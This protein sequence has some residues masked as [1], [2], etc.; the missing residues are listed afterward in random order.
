M[1]E[2]WSYGRLVV[3]LL[4]VCLSTAQDLQSKNLVQC[5]AATA[6]TNLTSLCTSC[7]SMLT[8]SVPLSG[9]VTK[10]DTH[11]YRLVL[12]DGQKPFIVTLVTSY[13]NADLKVWNQ[14]DLSQQP[15]YTSVAQLDPVQTIEVGSD[16]GI[17]VY[18]IGVYNAG[19]FA[20]TYS[21]SFT[22]TPRKLSLGVAFPHSVNEGCA[23]YYEF[24]VDKQKG[25]SPYNLTAR[26]DQLQIATEH[27]G[28]SD[29]WPTA[30]N[31]EFRLYTHF[32][33]LKRPETDPSLQPNL[34]YGLVGTARPGKALGYTVNGQRRLSGYPTKNEFTL[35][36]TDSE[37]KTGKYYLSVQLKAVSLV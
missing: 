16:L 26:P 24:Q 2:P 30:S 20:S 21:V 22:T 10:G 19:L 32:G 35:L 7:Y 12:C 15:D 1:P 4:C 23:Q 3:A 9:V 8:D 25:Q 6:C 14:P 31:S 17:T 36:S 5:T 34:T 11:L 33:V 37:Y 29:K 28:S 18:T 13:G 27:R